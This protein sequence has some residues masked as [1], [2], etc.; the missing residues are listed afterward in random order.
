VRRHDEEEAA[1]EKGAEE[2]SPGGIQAKN[3]NPTQSC[4]EERKKER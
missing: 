3:K 2:R 4:G 1:E